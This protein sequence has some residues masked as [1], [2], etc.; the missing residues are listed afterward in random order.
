[1]NGNLV[2]CP[3]YTV[4]GSP[5]STI[6][7]PGSRDFTAWRVRRR[8]EAYSRTFGCPH[9]Y[10]AKFGSFH[11][12]HHL[13]G[14]SGMSGFSSQNRPPGPYR[15]T[16]SLTNVAQARRPEG[17][18]GGKVFRAAANRGEPSRTGNTVIP[19]RVTPRTVSSVET[20]SRTPRRGSIPYHRMFA[21]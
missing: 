10:G 15:A 1:M 12:C 2:F 21:R 3:A 20:Q 9:Q 17:V 8:N 14:R 4:S 11:T 18:F 19:A 6:R 7:A 13:G 5:A 16:T